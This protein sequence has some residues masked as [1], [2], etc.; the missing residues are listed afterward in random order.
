MGILGIGIDLASIERVR[1]LVE[2]PLGERFVQRCFTEAERAYC[3]GRKARA[4]SYAARFAA[5]EALIK[6]L[7]GPRGLRWKD[8]EVVRE[9]G[10]APRF[11]LAGVA[12]REVER[13][14]ARVHLAL[15]HDAGAAAAT[16]ILEQEG[17]E[18]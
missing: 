12:A 15:T 13:R 16:V 18:R 6:A 5:K 3:D 4:E 14:R 7:G 2:G 10:G 1:R 11:R 17:G 9:A 8:M